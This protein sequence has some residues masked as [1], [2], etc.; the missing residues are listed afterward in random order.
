M[1]K[2]AKSLNNELRQALYVVL[3][4]EAVDA[5]G[6]TYDADEVRK[7]CHN[8]NQFCMQPNLFHMAD[9]SDFAIVE[10][11]CLPADTT[12]NETVLKA[13]TW[14][15]NL[16]FNTEEIWKAAKEDAFS[17]VSVGCVAYTE[18]LD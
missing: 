13:G 5:H 9:T 12:L 18:Y 14:M 8:F 17:G 6:D 15:V 2:I 1:Q 10:S 4:P 7:A 16:Q 11:Y 3:E